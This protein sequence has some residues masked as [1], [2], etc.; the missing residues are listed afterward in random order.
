MPKKRSPF[1][2]VLKW[3]F[4]A[5]RGKNDIKDGQILHQVFEF[6]IFIPVL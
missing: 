6:I 5:I 4:A 2:G 1:L 3:H